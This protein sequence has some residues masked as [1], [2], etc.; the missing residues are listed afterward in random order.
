MR[1]R[2]MSQVEKELFRKVRDNIGNTVLI[3]WEGCH[4]IYMA[5]DENTAGWYRDNYPHILEDKPEVMLNKLGEWWE[6][7]CRLRFINAVKS[8]NDVVQPLIFTPMIMQGEGNDYEDDEYDDE[9][10]EEDDFIFGEDDED[11]EY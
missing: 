8:T 1:E 4:K 5:M 2:K 3:A 10:D 9:D 11:E 6:L 7:S